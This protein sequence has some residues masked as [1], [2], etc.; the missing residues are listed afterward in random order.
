MQK[1]PNMNTLRDIWYL[2]QNKLRQI[3][4]KGLSN[5]LLTYKGE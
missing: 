3:A 4:W 2:G 5:I 1:A